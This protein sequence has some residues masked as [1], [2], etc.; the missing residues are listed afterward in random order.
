MLQHQNIEDCR[1]LNHCRPFRTLIGCLSWALASLYLGWTMS[2][3][4][5]PPPVQP[6]EV[7]H[8]VARGA[9]PL[10]LRLS[11]SQYRHTIIDIFGSSI[12]ITGNFEPETRVQGLLAIGNRTAN[13]SDTGIE[14]YDE[15]AR[16]CCLYRLSDLPLYPDRWSLILHRGGLSPPTPLPVSRRTSA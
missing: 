16:V 1:N 10:S 9:M 11:S 15:M 14:R 13:V 6:T 12:R 8:S 3:A 2:A 7:R 5:D 4:A